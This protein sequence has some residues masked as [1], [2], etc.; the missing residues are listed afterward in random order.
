[1]R[2]AFAARQQRPFAHRRVDVGANVG[3]EGRAGV[4]RQTFG[5]V[6]QAAQAVGLFQDHG[7]RPVA[8]APD[9]V[10]EKGHVQTEQQ[11]DD[12]DQLRRNVGQILENGA[13]ARRIDQP[14][15]QAD[16]GVG[17][18]DADDQQTDI[19]KLLKEIHRHYN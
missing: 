19:M 18:E 5:H 8:D 3:G 10:G 6:K 12:R 7:L 9:V 1:M 17:D 4:G 15:N 2:A 16:R 11:A 13:G 14:K